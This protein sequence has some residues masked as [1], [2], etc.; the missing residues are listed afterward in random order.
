MTVILLLVPA[1]FLVVAVAGIRRAE[2]QV[3]DAIAR[4]DRPAASTAAASAVQR[5]QRAGVVRERDGRL[6][7][8]AN[9]RET[10]E[11]RRRRQGILLAVVAVILLITSAVVTKR[12]LD[13]RAQGGAVPAA[14]TAR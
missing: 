2:Q 6:E 4:G 1:L 5:L 11:A 7:I 3:F 13:H 10:Y 9:R 12:V 8:E 14:A